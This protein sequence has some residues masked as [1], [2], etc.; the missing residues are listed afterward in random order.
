MLGYMDRKFLG[1]IFSTQDTLLET[2]LP[3][4]G[5]T[6]PRGGGVGGGCAHFCRDCRVGGYRFDLLK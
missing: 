4:K 6:L 3:L 5:K 1:I 2:V